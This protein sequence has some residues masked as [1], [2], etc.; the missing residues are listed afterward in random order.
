MVT[1]P[2]D[3]LRPDDGGQLA[4]NVPVRVPALFEAVPETMAVKLPWPGWDWPSKLQPSRVP[5]TTA[6]SACALV[7]RPGLRCT[8]P[9]SVVQDSTTTHPF[10][11]AAE[12]P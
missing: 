12:W 5:D 10:G 11:W 7:F 9:L 2:V 1:L 6:D 3:G 8:V 4:V